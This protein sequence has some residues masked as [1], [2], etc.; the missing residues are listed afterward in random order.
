MDTTLVI[1]A[2]VALL[3]VGLVVLAMRRSR[4]VSLQRRFGPEY[5]QAVERHGDAGKAEA[6]LAAREK[7]VSKLDIRPLPEAERRRFAEDWQLI[8]ARFVDG[9]PAAVAD[10]NRLV[11][12]V[13]QARGYP[14]GD[15][16]QR[17]ADVSVHHPMVAENYREARRIA[18]ASQRGQAT[19]EDLRQAVVYYREL[20][21]ELLDVPPQQVATGAAVH[22][23]AH[24]PA[25]ER[26]PELAGT[27]PADR[28]RPGR[29]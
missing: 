16:D 6:E 22:T 17:A 14:V 27:G 7:R 26:E 21:A 15:F 4:T 28:G 24:E 10:A 29:R 11:K 25:R 1:V 2:I 19:T 23:V 12:E 20:F 3:L 8:Q 9:P 18:E 5:R 13:M